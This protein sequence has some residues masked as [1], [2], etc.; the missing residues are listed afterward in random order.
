MFVELAL[1]VMM[2]HEFGAGLTAHSDIL[3]WRIDTMSFPL[4]GGVPFWH[5]VKWVMILGHCSLPF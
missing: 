5:R 1:R 4:A 3:Q 2:R